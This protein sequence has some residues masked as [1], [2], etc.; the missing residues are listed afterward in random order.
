MNV[1]VHADGSVSAPLCPYGVSVVRAWFNGHAIRV[2][3]LSLC[4][5][6]KCT[7][8]NGS[9]INKKGDITEKQMFYSNVG[10]VA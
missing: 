1:F 8:N 9:P 7:C 2:D 3:D 5:N 4:D 6:E 10:S